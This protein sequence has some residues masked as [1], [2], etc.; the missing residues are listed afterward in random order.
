MKSLQCEQCKKVYY[1]SYDYWNFVKEL[2]VKEAIKKRMRFKNLIS[3]G[4]SSKKEFLQR[5]KKEKEKEKVI[6][7]ICPQCLIF[8]KRL[9]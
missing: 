8:N 3:I 1:V 5:L 4:K 7:C 6:S 2:L 9:I